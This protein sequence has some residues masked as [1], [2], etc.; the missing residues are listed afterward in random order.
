MQAAGRVD[1]RVHACDDV[2]GV[3]AW[4]PRLEAE[5]ARRH[6]I[7]SVPEGFL[8]SLLRLGAQG[9][10]LHCSQLSLDGREISWMFSYLQKGVYY[11]Y[12]RAFD[13]SVAHLS[14]GVVHFYRLIEWMY[15]NG[16]HTIDF[17]LGDHAYKAEWTDGEAWEI[18]S[19]DLESPAAVSAARRTAAA[20]VSGLRQMARRLREAPL[21]PRFGA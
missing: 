16:G 12:Y 14:P 1:F 17:G 2:E 6:G 8:P 5:R 4:L 9:D 18:R 7:P 20:S 11:G 13:P 19:L 21:L 15:A 3:L 10:L